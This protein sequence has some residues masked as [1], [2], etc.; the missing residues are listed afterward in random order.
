M[1]KLIR[2]AHDDPPKD[3]DILDIVIIGE[4]IEGANTSDNSPLNDAFN[5]IR[6]YLTEQGSREV[7]N[8]DPGAE[9]ESSNPNGTSYYFPFR[10]IAPD[11][12]RYPIRRRYYVRVTYQFTS[13]GDK[14]E[15]TLELGEK[16]TDFGSVYIE[17]KKKRYPQIVTDAKAF[18]DSKVKEVHDQYKTDPSQLPNI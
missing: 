6:N 12:K 11:N 2:G 5:S 9:Y 18:I 8:V 13:L 10:V 3:S 17:G 7:G 16:P 14:H 4:S 1:K 15:P